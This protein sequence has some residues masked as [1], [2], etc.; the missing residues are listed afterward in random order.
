MRVLLLCALLWAAW[1]VSESRAADDPLAVIVNRQNETGNLSQAELARIYRGESENWP[2]GQRIVAVTRPVESE[3]R[4]QF[5]R[6]VLKVGP[7]QQFVPAGTFAP[8]EPM[9]LQSAAATRKLVARIP[10]VVGYIFFSEADETVKILKIDGRLPSEPGY[11]L[12]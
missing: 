10:N 2:D 4:R 3:I 1:P 5:Y 12:R 8:F 9:V 7:N 6:L 11:P